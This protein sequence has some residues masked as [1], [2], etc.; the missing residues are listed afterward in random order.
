V[1]S[2]TIGGLVIGA[3][4]FWVCWKAAA[5]GHGTYLPAIALFPLAMALAILQDLIS[6]LLIGLALAQ[7]PAYGFLLG[8]EHEAGTRLRLAWK[9][10]AIHLLA[11]VGAAAIALLKDGFRP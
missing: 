3:G 11:A 6:P 9:L 7:F 1:A 5:F 8:R 10:G 4:L 2:F